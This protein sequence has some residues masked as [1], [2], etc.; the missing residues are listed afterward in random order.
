MPPPRNDQA[1]LCTLNIN[2]TQLENATSLLLSRRTQAGY[3]E[4]ARESIHS[5]FSPSHSSQ[6]DLI[7][8]TSAV[9]FSYTSSPSSIN[10]S[11]FKINSN[12]KTDSK[13]NSKKTKR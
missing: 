9:G 3:S 12:L 13:F 11:K 1:I 5:L 4:P 8:R 2:Q 10:M 6:Q 7:Q